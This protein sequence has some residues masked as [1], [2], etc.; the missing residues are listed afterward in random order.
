MFLA[1][2]DFHART[3]SLYS[4]K[5]DEG[6]SPSLLSPYLWDGFSDFDFFSENMIALPPGLG[7]GRG[8]KVGFLN[9]SAGL[10]WRH[11][12]CMLLIIRESRT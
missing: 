2:S 11:K 1:V 10:C 9:E 5:N 4:L 6:T 7:L 12:L 8:L 3:H